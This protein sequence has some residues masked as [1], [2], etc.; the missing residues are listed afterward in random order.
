[1]RALEPAALALPFAEEGGLEGLWTTAQMV[2]TT[3]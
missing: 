3:R 2:A 1:M